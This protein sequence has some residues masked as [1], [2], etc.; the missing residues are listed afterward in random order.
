M[1]WWG[2][3]SYW[4]VCDYPGVVFPRGRFHT[5]TFEQAAVHDSFPPHQP[6][7]PTEAFVH[8]QW[9]P[10]TYE[11]APISLQLIGTRLNEERLLKILSVVERS[12]VPAAKL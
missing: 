10:L 9:S 7:N 11:N 3:S 6:R 1:R 12:V 8:E 5:A 4:N 2:Y